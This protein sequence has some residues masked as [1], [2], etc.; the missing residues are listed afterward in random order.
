MQSG[1]RSSMSRALHERHG[2]FTAKRQR[3]V[4]PETR[5]A[6]ISFYSNVC[7]SR[8]IPRRRG[9]KLSPIWRQVVRLCR[10]PGIVLPPKTRRGSFDAEVRITPSR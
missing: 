7:S 10:W 4:V 1:R 5:L 8:V 3:S 9:H 6:H 2:G